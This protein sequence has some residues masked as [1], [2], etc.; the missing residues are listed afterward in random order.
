MMKKEEKVSF[1]LHQDVRYVFVEIKDL[2]RALSYLHQSL[3]SLDLSWPALIHSERSSTGWEFHLS[4]SAAQLRNL[5]DRLKAFPLIHVSETN[6]ISLQA[7]PY[8]NASEAACHLR[9]EG[10]RR[11]LN[12]R[13]LAKGDQVTALIPHDQ[14]TRFLETVQSIPKPTHLI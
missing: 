12:L 8:E 6:W 10:Q 13:L 1:R 14:Q 4:G 11:G 2:G 7:S 3:K 5:R 9:D